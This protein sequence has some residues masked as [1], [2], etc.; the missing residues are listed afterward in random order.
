MDADPAEPRVE[1]SSKPVPAASHARCAGEVLGQQGGGNPEPN[2]PRRVVGTCPQP[3]LLPAAVDERLDQRRAT[4]HAGVPVY[5]QRAYP[6]WTVHLV[7]ANRHQVHPKLSEADRNA[8]WRL[9]SV[10]V[11]KRAT[12]VSQAHDRVER[13]QDA[14]LVVCEHDRHEK[15][16]IVDELDEP[17]EI[18][19]TIVE[20]RHLQDPSAPIGQDLR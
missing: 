10:G 20:D 8:A 19:P 15:R 4:G 16:V 2:N 12:I 17:V 7:P 11:N 3:T 1:C 18:D 6:A 9:S 14:G 5:E 13:V